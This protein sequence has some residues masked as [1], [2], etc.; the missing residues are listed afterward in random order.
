VPSP[1]R[2]AGR[3]K[4]ASHRGN[5]I[6]AEIPS[7]HR[8]LQYR[9]RPAVRKGACRKAEWLQRYRHLVGRMPRRSQAKAFLV[10]AS[11]LP[12]G[13]MVMDWKASLDNYLAY[14]ISPPVRP[15]AHQARY[16]HLFLA[17]MVIASLKKPSAK[18]LVVSVNPKRLPSLSRR[19]ISL[20]NEFICLNLSQPAKSSPLPM[21]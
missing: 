15:L 16:L 13:P 3:K 21:K 7:K 9:M 5:S 18:T 20:S 19:S 8:I 6:T 14:L 10:L 12:V 4:R 2:Q 1:P 11:L 17:R